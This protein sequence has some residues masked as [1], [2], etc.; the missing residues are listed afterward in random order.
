M[1]LSRNFRGLK[2]V[3]KKIHQVLFDAATA[4]YREGSQCCRSLWKNRKL[5]NHLHHLCVVQFLGGLRCGWQKMYLLFLVQQYTAETKALAQLRLSH[6]VASSLPE[7]VHTSR[8]ITLFAQHYV[9]QFQTE[10]TYCTLRIIVRFEVQQ[11]LYIHLGDCS[12]AALLAFL[13]F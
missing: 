10:V 6:A 5:L 4:L 1:P 2:C 3:G 7:N 12:A 9:L 13:K 11:Y 8:S